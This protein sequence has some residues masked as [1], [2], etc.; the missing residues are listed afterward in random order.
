MYRYPVPLIC[1]LFE[2]K[3]HVDLK[4][5]PSR[6]DC[7]PTFSPPFFTPLGMGHAVIVYLE[8]FNVV[9]GSLNMPIRVSPELTALRQLR[10]QATSSST[11][12]L[13]NNRPH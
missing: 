2:P 1:T 13:L 5:H 7:R 10:P 6:S 12:S 4:Q 8:C 3:L 11:C 9:Q